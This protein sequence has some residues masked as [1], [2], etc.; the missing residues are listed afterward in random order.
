MTVLLAVYAPI[1]A[2]DSQSVLWLGIVGLAALLSGAAFYRVITPWVVLICAGGY[3]YLFTRVVPR[4]PMDWLR[5]TRG[6]ESLA[7]AV[8]GVWL[9][10]LFLWYRARVRKARR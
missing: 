3:L 1:Q 5:Y 4:V 6:R 8:C 7:L 2:W 9:L 10:V